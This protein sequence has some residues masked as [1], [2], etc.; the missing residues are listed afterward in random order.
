[1]MD[2]DKFDWIIGGLC[3]ATLIGVVLLFVFGVFS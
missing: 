2:P 1:M 3:W